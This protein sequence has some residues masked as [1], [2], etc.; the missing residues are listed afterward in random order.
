MRARK[1]AA[2]V[3][4][5]AL[6]AGSAV[7]ARAATGSSRGRAR[8][9][10]AAFVTRILREELRGQWTRQWD[11]LHP[12]HR[13][14][15]TQAQFVA[16]SRGLATGLGNELLTVIGVHSA[17]IRVQG[18]PQHTAEV[19]EITMRGPGTAEA[20]TFRIHAVHVAGRWAWIL[21]KPFLQ[22]IAK[23][24]CLDGS[25]LQRSAPPA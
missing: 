16:C 10:A 23:G 22:A 7:T 5:V 25:P 6:L 19:V 21:G 3:A 15:I 11:E 2:A 20:V 24:R 14:L 17:H 4:L 13:R 18:V 8:E 9:T 12:G 1:L